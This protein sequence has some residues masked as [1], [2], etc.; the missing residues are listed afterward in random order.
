MELARRGWAHTD[1]A[2]AAGISPPTVS[3]AVAGRPVAP[4][5]LRKIADALAS[6]P[7]VEGIDVLLRDRL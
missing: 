7:V 6:T 5:T 3:A 2:R 1:L 4:S